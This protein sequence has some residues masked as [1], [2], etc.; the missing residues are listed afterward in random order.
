MYVDIHTHNTY[1]C[2]WLRIL[3]RLSI[4]LSYLID[5]KENNNHHN[6]RNHHRRY[7]YHIHHHC[8]HYY[9][10]NYHHYHH[11]PNHLCIP[12]GFS[13]VSF[14][15]DDL[16]T[17]LEASPFKDARPALLNVELLGREN[18]ILYSYFIHLTFI[19]WS[20]SSC[21][22]KDLCD[23]LAIL[24]LGCSVIAVASFLCMFIFFTYAMLA[25]LICNIYVFGLQIL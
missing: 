15:V 12:V 16:R 5:M 20:V 24:S 2:A 21:C 10:H 6:C 3:Y 7:Y 11:H 23:V 4:V 18:C 9:Y 1:T 22:L 25:L 14:I 8:N 13:F 19:M 17:L